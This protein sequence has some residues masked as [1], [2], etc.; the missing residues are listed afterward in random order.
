MSDQRP[1]VALIHASPASVAPAMA[2]FAEEFP[3]ANL[4]NL[5]DDR[6]VVDA[7]AAGGLTPALRERMTTLIKYAVDGGADAVQLSCSMYGPVA[8]DAAGS[9]RFTVLASDQA[10]FD[11]VAPWPRRA[12][13]S[14][15]RSPRPHQTVPSALRAC[16]EARLDAEDRDARCRRRR[17]S[18]RPGDLDRPPSS[19]HDAAQRWRQ[20]RPHRARPVLAGTSLPRGRG[21]RRARS[22]ALLTWQPP[23]SRASWEGP[24]VIALGC[25]A[26]D[27]TGGTDVAAALR[28]A[29]MSVALLFGVPEAEAGATHR[30]RGHRP[31]DPDRPGGGCRR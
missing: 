29:G 13:A 4:W 26:D 15:A 18:R 25:I 19:S 22:S 21:R 6:L 20:R 16:S 5:L 23:P 1:T 24:S 12:S 9:D 28:R 17:G 3:D 8:V 11:H 10:M 2:A 7:D 30:R 27:F 31:E 14:S